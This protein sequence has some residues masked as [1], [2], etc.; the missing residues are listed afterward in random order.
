MMRTINVR[1]S[2]EKEVMRFGNGSIVYTPKKWIGEKVLVVLEE[3]PLDIA[4]EV[5]EII[6]P[7]LSSI[8]GIFLFGSFSRNEQ[9]KKSDIDILVVADRKI[10]LRKEGR[11]DFLVKTR[12]ELEKELQSDS[13]LFLYGVVNEAKPV[14]NGQLLEELKK[15]EVKPD[16]GKFFDETVGAF[17]KTSELLEINK[18]REVLDSN[19]AIY[20]L[21]LR[22]KSIFMIQCY[23]KGAEFSNKKFKELIKSHGFSE[24][25]TENL[26]EVYRAER[27]EEKTGIKILLDDAKKLFEAAKIEFV[28][29]EEL[30]KNGKRKV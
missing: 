16:F 20:S 27:D 3:K 17:K 18:G 12:G 19:T 25:T 1:E 5:M 13:T 30:V 6:K 22:L 9:T 24:K 8:E 15:I 4:A 29:T 14:L 23:K 26:L 7:H 11:F 28:K 21:I 10:N 2:V